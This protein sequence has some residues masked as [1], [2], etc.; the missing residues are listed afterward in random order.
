LHRSLQEGEERTRLVL[1]S[2]GEAIVG[3]D[4]R[5]S[6]IFAN[7]ACARALG[8]ASA[9]DLFGKDIRDL[10]QPAEPD[11]DGTGRSPLGRIDELCLDE[12]PAHVPE[13]RLLRADGTTFW[14]ECRSYPIRRAGQRVGA[15]ITFVDITERKRAAQEHDR[16]LRELEEAV[17]LR[18]DFLAIASH[19]LRTPLTPLQLHVQGIQRALTRGGADGISTV[20]I[21]ARLEAV[22]RQISRIERL[23]DDLLD[24]GR[25]T[26]KTVPL[27]LEELELGALVRELIA[28]SE[29]DLARARCEVRLE[30]DGPVVGRWD[31]HRLEQ[32][33][34]NLLSNAMKFGAGKCIDVRVS[35]PT[36][37]GVARVV[38]RDHGIGIQ[39]AD[40]RRVF[41]RFERAVP[42]RHYGGFGLGLWMAREVLQAMGGV[43]TVES[44]LGEGA[45]FI[46]EVPIGAGA[47]AHALAS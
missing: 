15:V 30:I 36:G 33:L 28:Q 18:D 31:R 38:V 22:A 9:E 46:V 27:R 2:V 10:L 4:P 17:R 37:R 39:A 35:A 20:E 24:T 25:I 8:Y 26:G 7:P 42:S 44:A 23:V 6:C 5:G 11:P 12:S 45:T 1:E 34:S 32:V 21:L 3:V 13:E 47:A 43:V 41:E 40:Q 29:R 19:E 16:V 14:A